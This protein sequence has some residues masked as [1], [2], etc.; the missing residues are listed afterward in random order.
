MKNNKRFWYYVIRPLE[1]PSIGL[2]N[3]EY[4]SKSTHIY[5]PILR[6]HRS[7]PSWMMDDQP[8]LSD[9]FTVTLKGKHIFTLTNPEHVAVVMA[10]MMTADQQTDP[11]MEVNEML[12]SMYPQHSL[13]DVVTPF[14]K[15]D[16]NKPFTF[17]VFKDKR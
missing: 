16:N 15:G 2:W 9:P 14:L 5:Y 10:N 12:Y 7:V 4:M 6:E 8:K 3:E 17:T 1:K 13:T 11:V